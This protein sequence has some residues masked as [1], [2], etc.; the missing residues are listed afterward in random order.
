MKRKKCT[1]K[2]TFPSDT[3][4]SF[5]L[6]GCAIIVSHNDRIVGV[7]HNSVIHSEVTH[8]ARPSCSDIGDWNRRT[9]LNEQTAF[10]RVSRSV[11]NDSADSG[12]S[13]SWQ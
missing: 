8:I 7:A 5:M 9:W 1:K 6:L 3:S 12:T 2:I 11:C 4:S 10:L 13:G